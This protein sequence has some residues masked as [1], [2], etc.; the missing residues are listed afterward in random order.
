MGEEARRAVGWCRGGRSEAVVVVVLGSRRSGGVDGGGC[1]CR[2]SVVGWLAGCLA[3]GRVCCGAQ[4]L[5]VLSGGSSPGGGCALG[6]VLA[7]LWLV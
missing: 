1:W 2:G 7:G 5:V 4:S 3:P 6:S